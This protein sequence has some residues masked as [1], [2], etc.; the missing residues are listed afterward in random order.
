MLKTIIVDDEPKARRIMCALIEQHCPDLEI[1]GTADDVPSAVKLINKTKPDL[2]FLDIEMPGFTGFQLMDFFETVDFQIIFTTAYSEYALQAF[3]V[4][5]IDYLL[6]PIEVSAL[7][8]S[9]E[10]ALKQQESLNQ[11]QR[12]EALAANLN[13]NGAIK[14]IALPVADGFMFVEPE[15]VLYLKADGSYTNIYLVDGQKFLVTK[16]IKEFVRILNHPCFFKTHR[17]YLINLNQIK[18]YVKN[19]GGYIVM[20]NGDQVTLARDRKDEFLGAIS[21]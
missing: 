3:Q 4:S 6:K 15:D 18:Q 8:D 1:L 16:K 17:S 7:K 13:P 20:G 5:A 12:L 10:K 14:K 19:D 2:V 9:V 11:D 21:S